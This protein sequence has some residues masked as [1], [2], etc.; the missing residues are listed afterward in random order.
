MYFLLGLKK[1]QF[2]SNEEKSYVKP[3]QYPSFKGKFG[4]I[5][6]YLGRFCEYCFEEITIK[7]ASSDLIKHL[8]SKHQKEFQNSQKNIYQWQL[9]LRTLKFKMH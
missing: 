6:M 8:H 3:V 4:K 2:L 7:R 1:R 5:K 9:K